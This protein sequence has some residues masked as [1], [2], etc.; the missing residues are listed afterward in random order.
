[1]L[2]YRYNMISIY[3]VDGVFQLC[4]TRNHKIFTFTFGKEL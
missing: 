1:M 3:D 2:F 4:Y